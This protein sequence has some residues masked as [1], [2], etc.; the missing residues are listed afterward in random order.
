MRLEMAD[1]QKGIEA[2][3]REFRAFLRTWKMEIDKWHFVGAGFERWQSSFLNTVPVFDGQAELIRCDF[4]GKKREE[5]E[6][7]TS[8]ITGRRKEDKA[9]NHVEL[10]N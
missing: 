8:A 9:Y 4:V 10:I 5:F 3:W 2:R 7:L 1:G 6:R